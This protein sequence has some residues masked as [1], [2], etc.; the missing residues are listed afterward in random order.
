VSSTAL[1]LRPDVELIGQYQGSGRQTA[2]YLAK[3]P[4]GAF[5]ELT[6]VL[7]LIT[8]ALDGKRSSADVARMVGGQVGLEVTAADV[9]Y[10]IA[11]LLPLGLIETEQPQLER[12]DMV[13][14]LRVKRAVLGVRLVSALTR[15]L[16]HLFHWPIVVVVLAGFGVVLAD[17][18]RHGYLRA[19]IDALVNKPAQ[20]LV[21][22]GLLLVAMVFHELGHASACRFGG[23]KPGAIG[24]GLYLMWPALYTDVTDATRLKRS[25]RIRT[26]LGGVY[27]NAVMVGVLGA[28]YQA[29]HYLP[30]VLAIAGS[31][32]LMAEQLLPFVRFDG[33][34][35]VS[36]A[37]GVP[38]L[39]PRLAEALHRRA[40]GKHL[41]REGELKPYSRRIIRAWASFTVVVLPLELI[42]LLLLSATLAVT[43][44]F[45]IAHQFS[46]V[47]PDM[48]VNNTPAVALD[49]VQGLLLVLLMVG[50]AYAL[51]FLTIKIV[52]YATRRFN[53]V[54]GILVLAVLAAPVVWSALTLRVASTN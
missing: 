45:G 47:Q 2:S 1:E 8:A 32:L 46:H 6:Q 52:T 18:V 12:P 24:G 49:L 38:D 7:Y 33:Y 4:D 29:T 28:I 10:L 15:G 27:F 54:V 3:R 23:A 50:L 5:V 19:S 35:I 13:L 11:K 30:L 14:G 40:K 21:V 9:D 26:D 51:C 41:N 20:T 36:D 22:L 48:A 53:V 17:T 25:G 31:V 37:A 42:V 39:F 44:A 43:F 16:Q 34:W